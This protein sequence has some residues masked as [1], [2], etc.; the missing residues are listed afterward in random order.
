MNAWMIKSAFDSASEKKVINLCNPHEKTVKFTKI[1]SSEVPF[2]FTQWLQS[3]EPTKLMGAC[4]KIYVIYSTCGHW[5]TGGGGDCPPMLFK[6]PVLS[7][8]LSTPP[9]LIKC[10]FFFWK[11]FKTF[12]KC[13]SKSN[14]HNF[15]LHFLFSCWV[16][17]LHLKVKN[18][19]NPP[20]STH[21]YFFKN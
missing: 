8:C 10:L 12:K 13:F 11:S 20:L 18:L 19:K 4:H 15:I 9:I 2:S 5:G 3:L 14:I 7:N 17:Y 1:K 16:C 6:Y 21:C